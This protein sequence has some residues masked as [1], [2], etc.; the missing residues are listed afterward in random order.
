MLDRDRNQ[1]KFIDRFAISVSVPVNSSIERANYT[2]VFG[3]AM[4]EV[5]FYIVNL[6]ESNPTVVNSME[7][8]LTDVNNGYELRLTIYSYRNPSHGCAGCTKCCDGACNRGCDTYFYLCVRPFQTTFSRNEKI[9]Q[10]DCP[11]DEVVVTE[12]EDNKIYGATFS[13]IVLGVDNPIIFSK[14]T[15]VSHTKYSYVPIIR[16]SSKR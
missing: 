13:D 9:F 16:W 15:N 12:S 2:G 1:D 14:I 4:L 3:V 6:T 8:T 10:R 7:S 11:S 5:S